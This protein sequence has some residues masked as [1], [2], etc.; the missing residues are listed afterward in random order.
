MCE[1]CVRSVRGDGAPRWPWIRVAEGENA[2]M[3]ARRIRNLFM[4]SKD[5]SCRSYVAASKQP[6]T[7]ITSKG[8]RTRILAPFPRFAEVGERC[9]VACTAAPAGGSGLPALRGRV[10]M[11]SCCWLCTKAAPCPLCG[12]SN[13]NW[14]RWA[15]MTTEPGAHRQGFGAGADRHPPTAVLAPPP[16]TGAA[17][18]HHNPQAPVSSTQQQASNHGHRRQGG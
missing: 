14:L 4:M 12:W 16:A 5:V 18:K 1:D 11:D 10:L 2:S 13:C 15:G 6:R 17:P 3:D 9:L 7:N 8:L